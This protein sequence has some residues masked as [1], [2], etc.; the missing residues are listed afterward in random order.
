[1]TKKE[2]IIVEFEGV[3]YDQQ[4]EEDRRSFLSKP[5]A[6]GIELLQEL[7]KT[8]EV[9]L[10]SWRPE[11]KGRAYRVWICSWLKHHGMS[12]DEVA[13]VKFTYLDG[14]PWGCPLLT[15][16]KNQA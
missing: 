14:M 8:R 2:K 1:M 5:T 9:Y 3:V 6:K 15:A 10:L 11:S 12:R 13:L 16:R 4:G 7:L